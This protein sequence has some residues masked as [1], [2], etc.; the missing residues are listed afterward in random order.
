LNVTIQL[1]RIHQRGLSIRDKQ[2][3]EKQET[4]SMS[5]YR[6]LLKYN[7]PFVIMDTGHISPTECVNMCVEMIHSK[8]PVSV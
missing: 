2:T 6:N 3:I 8:F 4:I 7:V 5:Y 1:K